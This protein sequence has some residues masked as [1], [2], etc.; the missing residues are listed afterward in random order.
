MKLEKILAGVK[1]NTSLKNHTTFKIG[2]RAKYFFE[3]RK[4]EDLILAIKAAKALGLPFF[5]LGKGSNLLISDQ[6]FKGLVIKNQIS[7]ITLRG[8]A[9][10]RK[11]QKDK[12]N[13][14]I[15][16]E[17]GTPLA[18]LVL[19]ALKSGAKGFEWAV[20]IPGT[21]GGA[22][23]GNA[24]AF[25]K[26]ISDNVVEVEMLDAGKMTV[27]RL[28]K[29]DCHF[30][31]RESIFKKNKNSVILEAIFLAK[32]GNKKEIQNKIKE[33][34]FRRREKQPL[35]LPSIGSIFKNPAGKKFSA[36]E[37]IERVGLKGK[38]AGGVEVSEKHS[39]FF[40]NVNRGKSKDVK[41][42]I[43]LAKKRVKNKFG[44]ELKEEIQYLGP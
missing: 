34:L 15:V 39:N 17:A 5:I 38:R 13:I 3:A 40:L 11:T 21:V 24:G 6:G 19:E 44:I 35:N 33:Y 7:K 31:Y 28:K 2:G 27:E 26:S 23:Y 9:S 8:V 4:K 1:K 43:K 10:D 22:V 41:N 25:G 18:T 29:G 30:G 42:L 36:G 16:A 12:K 37:L 32:K 20:G 14:K